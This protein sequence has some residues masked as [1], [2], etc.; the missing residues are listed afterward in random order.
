MVAPK[1]PQRQPVPHP[2]IVDLELSSGPRR[3]GVHDPWAADQFLRCRTARRS[4]ELLGCKIYVTID[5]GSLVC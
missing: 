2:L 1:Y 3:N 5:I 4:V